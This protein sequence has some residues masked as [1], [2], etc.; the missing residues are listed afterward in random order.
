MPQNLNQQIREA[1]TRA[2]LTQSQLAERADVGKMD[3]WRFEKGQNV[4][5]KTFL[6]IVNAVPNL[7]RLDLGSVELTK[8]EAK[9]LDEREQLRARASELLQKTHEERPGS[10]A[11][12]EGQ[13]APSAPALDSR[14]EWAMLRTIA[15]LLYE[16]TGAWK[17]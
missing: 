10:N 1:R 9:P 4:T 14:R 13:P 7:T 17:P 3:V 16:L 15:E 5:L 6:K 2:G 12:P 8:N 11:A